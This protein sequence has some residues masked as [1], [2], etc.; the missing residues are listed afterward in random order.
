MTTDLFQSDKFTSYLIA[1]EGK[2]KIDVI[3]FFNALPHNPTDKHTD[4]ILNTLNLVEYIYILKQRNLVASTII[5]KH[6]N[7][8]LF[9][10]YLLAS[11]LDTTTSDDTNINSKCEA[12]LKWLHKR[13]K[14][15]WKDVKMQ[16]F[17][18]ALK[19]EQE[20]DV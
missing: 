6:K 9:I 1:V 12:T 10:E 8:R 20:I 5:D 3:K 17:A 14:V 16:Q 4:I 18:N 19:A 13:A 11:N 2:S 15:L 7:L